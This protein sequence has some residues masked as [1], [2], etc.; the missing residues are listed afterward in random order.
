MWSLLRTRRWIAF[1]TLVIVA[2]AA[3]GFLSRWQWQRAEERRV[4]RQ[5]LVA[6]SSQDLAAIG[7]ID[8]EAP[9]TQWEWRPVQVTGEYLPDSTVLVRQRPLDGRNGLWVVSALQPADGPAVWINR[10]WIP[11]T[12]GSTTVVVAP[13]PPAGE[14]TVDGRLRPLQSLDGPAPT[15]LPVGQVSAL[16]AQELAAVVAAPAVPAYVERVRSS[17]AEPDLTVLPLPVIDEGRNISYAVQWLLFAAVAIIGWYFF[18]RREARE[19]AR[20][21][22]DADGGDSPEPSTQPAHT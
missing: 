1:T 5:T 2:I 13:A 22:A 18:L 7:S 9:T 3:F 16:D 19:D 10:G 15:D 4:E 8:L 11:A 17:P 14:V 21:A 20:L 12:G 6:E